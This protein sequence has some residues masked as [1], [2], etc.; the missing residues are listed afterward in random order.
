MQVT[1]QRWAEGMNQGGLELILGRNASTHN[2]RIGGGHIIALLLKKFL[3]RDVQVLSPELTTL[4]LS[5][6]SC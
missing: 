2:C 3:L 4:A 6:G 1:S 5:W